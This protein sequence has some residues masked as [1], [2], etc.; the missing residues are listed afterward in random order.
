MMRLECHRP[1]AYALDMS[2]HAPLSRLQR[3]GFY[4]LTLLALFMVSA[5]GYVLATGDAEPA[6]AL[7]DFSDEPAL[8]PS[9]APSIEFPERLRTFDSDVNRFIDRFI[10][11][12]REGRYSEFRKMWT[13]SIDPVSKDGYALIWTRVR[14]VRI[15][16]VARIARPERPDDVAYVI[17]ADVVMDDTAV[18]KKSQETYRMLIVR[19]DG[20]WV[21]APVSQLKRGEAE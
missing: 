9:N 7:D 1:H 11:V 5:V 8:E 15:T 12:T 13:R 18:Q 6:V 10:R 2:S 19:E 17:T 16:S 21:F 20:A 3:M 4:G 14:Q